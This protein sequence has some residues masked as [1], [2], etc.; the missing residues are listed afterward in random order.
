MIRSQQLCNAVSLF[1]SNMCICSQPSCW[2]PSITIRF[3][4][5]TSLYLTHS[6]LFSDSQL[7]YFVKTNLLHS[8]SKIPATSTPSPF[9]L[10]LNP[11]SS[12]FDPPPPLVAINFSSSSASHGFSS[13]RQALSPFSLRSS[14][15]RGRGLNIEAK[16]GEY[17]S[18]SE[19][20]S[21]QAGRSSR[22][23]RVEEYQ[24]QVCPILANCRFMFRFS[25]GK[26]YLFV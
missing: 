10:F 26:L 9:T 3:I 14:H 20:S 15:W 2:L 22:M 19:Q 12:L 13:P 8:W 24:K 4:T 18:P 6:L 1:R 7:F 17:S 16:D 23:T 11:A 5:Y 21:L 25:S